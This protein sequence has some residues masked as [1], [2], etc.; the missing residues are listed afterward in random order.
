MRCRSNH[1]SDL[2]TPGM[3][4]A[5]VGVLLP[6]GPELASTILA[7]MTTGCTVVPLNPAATDPEI[8]LVRLMMHAVADITR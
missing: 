5:R 1:S 6:N 2:G 7:V 8:A 3:Q 4:R